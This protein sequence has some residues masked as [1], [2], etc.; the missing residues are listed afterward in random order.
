[1]W[2]LS[3]HLISEKNYGVEQVRESALQW[4]Q[5]I[6]S[7]YYVIQELK[8]RGVDPAAYGL[9][10]ENPCYTGKCELPFTQGGCGGMGSL[11]L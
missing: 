6:H 4:L 3:K 7:D 8:N 10:H 11:K 2:G 9:V 1:V 5:F